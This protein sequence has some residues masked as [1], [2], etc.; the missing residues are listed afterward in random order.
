MRDPNR[1]DEVL[2]TL[3]AYWKKHPDLRLGQIIVNV[4]GKSDPFYVEDETLLTKLQAQ[5]N[6]PGN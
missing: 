4:T 1:I 5:L 6:G 3:S 2:E